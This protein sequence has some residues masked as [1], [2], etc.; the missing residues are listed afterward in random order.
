MYAQPPQGVLFK[1]VSGGKSHSC[2]VDLEGN[3]HCWGITNGGNWDYGQVT[4]APTEGTFTYAAAGYNH[5]CAIKE[6][7][8]ALCWGIG[9]EDNL[10]P[11]QEPYEKG[12][13]T[14]TPTEPVFQQIGAG[15]GHTCGLKM[16]GSL[17][18]WGAGSGSNN[19]PTGTGFVSLAVG[20]HHN[21][22]L[23]S[24]R[25]LTCWGWTAFGL[26]EDVPEGTFQSVS[27]GYGHTCAVRTSGEVVCWGVP[28]KGEG[29]PQ[30][31]DSGQ[32]T[33]APTEPNFKLVAVNSSHSCAVTLGNKVMC[34]GSN[35]SGKSTPPAELQ[36]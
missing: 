15:H 30:V 1:Q 31:V 28:D 16:D 34:W 26:V 2:G 32:S 23:D 24:D 3:V 11:G 21:C 8:T 19:V 36:P 4:L 35:S 10:T 17:Q 22:A 12:Q 6:D 18:C 7:G 33:D 9:S 14:L 20:F 13:V 5:S 29:A 25:E 27:C